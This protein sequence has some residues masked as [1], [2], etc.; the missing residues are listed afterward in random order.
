[1][2]IPNQ[3]VSQ[4]VG[5]WSYVSDHAM[6]TWQNAAEDIEHRRYSPTKLMSD[7]AGWWNVA[8]LGWWT[9]LGNLDGRP[10]VV[11][12]VIR[13]DTQAAGKTIPVLATTMP[14]GDPQLVWLAGPAAEGRHVKALTKD[15]IKLRWSK[16]KALIRIDLVDLADPSVKPPITLQPGIYQALIRVGEVPVANVDVEVG[17]PPQ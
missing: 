11:L 13:P 14:D 5:Y 17:P 8:A 6:R 3:F 10:R 9:A 16:E 12:F 7:V 15:N 1:M 2:E 4:F